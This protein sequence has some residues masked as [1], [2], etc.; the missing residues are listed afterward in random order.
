MEVHNHGY[1]YSTVIPWLFN[2][3]SMVI[4]RLFHGYSTVIPGYS[5]VIHGQQ[6]MI[7]VRITYMIRILPEQLQKD[8]S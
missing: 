3:Y 1:S 2:G 7:T 6:S 8:Q 4:Q 5:T